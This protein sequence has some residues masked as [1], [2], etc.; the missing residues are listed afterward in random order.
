MES[1][2]LQLDVFGGYGDCQSSSMRMYALGSFFATDVGCPA[3][4]W[5]AWIR[6]D[7][8]G[9]DTSGNITLLG[10]YRSNIHLCFLYNEQG[11]M[12]DV[13]IAKDRIVISRDNLVQLIED[14]KAKVCAHKPQSVTIADHGDLF[15]LTRSN[16]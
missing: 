12:D 9:L 3:T 6:D 14:W 15:V 8:Q 5:K 13:R 7:S 1:V 11:K 2:T 4:D 10:K 16:D